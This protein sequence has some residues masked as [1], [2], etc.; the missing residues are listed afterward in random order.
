MQQLRMPYEECVN[1]LTALEQEFEGNSTWPAERVPE[2]I[3][4]WIQPD[5]GNVQYFSVDETTRYSDSGRVIV[6]TGANFSQGPN[7]LANGVHANLRPWRRGL[8]AV[9]EKYE[10]GVYPEYWS[11]GEWKR[12]PLHLFSSRSIEIPTRYYYVQTNVVPWITTV[13]WSDIRGHSRR[14]RFWSI[15]PAIFRGASIWAGCAM[16][17][18]LTHCGRATAIMKSTDSSW[19]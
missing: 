18:R 19:S 1:S 6:S 15:R 9:L 3:R 13:L 2:V 17:C 14:R 10:E 11:P 12:E 16:C 5:R 8:E 7:Q 4:S